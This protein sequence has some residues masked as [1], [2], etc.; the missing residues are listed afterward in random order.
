[1]DT[2]NKKLL[3][4]N[5]L[6]HQVTSDILQ[7]AFIPFGEIAQIT[8]PPDPS[9]STNPHRG[10]A[11]L[12]FEDPEDALAAIDNMHDSELFGRTITVRPARANA[13]SKHTA[14]AEAAEVS[15]TESKF[16]G[17][18]PRVFIEFAVDGQAS[19]R[20]VLEVR[21]DV[22]PKTARNFMALC[23]GERGFGYKGSRVHRIVPG[24]MVQM[25]DFTKGD[26]TGG[27]CIYGDRF[28]DENFVLNHDSAGVL[29]MANAGPNTNGSQFFLTL[30]KTP[31]LDGKHVVFGRV[32]QGMDILRMVEALGD[33]DAPL[34][35]LKNITICDC[36]IV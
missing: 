29:S 1:M 4:I 26:G 27:K 2:Q 23:T 11:L 35:P 17:D 12:E 24:F 19:G 7:A 32:V 5:G 16:V 33:K 3:F 28:D 21:R 20:V 9:S 36:G 8:M 30:D 18:N 10:F 15:K 6:D 34:R 31:W 22:A 25:G 14:V 13:L